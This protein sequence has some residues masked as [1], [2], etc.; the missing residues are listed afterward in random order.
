MKRRD[1]LAAAAALPIAAPAVAQNTRATTLRMVPQANLAVLDPIFTTATVTGNHGFYVFDTLYGV[2]EHLKPKPQM[3]VQSS[4]SW[5]ATRGGWRCSLR[6][7][8]L[9]STTATMSRMPAAAV[10]G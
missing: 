1:F 6:V 7:W 2:D 4:H 9:Y 5:S 3:A 10:S 8:T